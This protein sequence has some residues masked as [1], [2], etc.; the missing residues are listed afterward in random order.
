MQTDLN[1]LFGWSPTGHSPADY[2]L[3]SVH[4]MIRHGDRYPL[5]SIPKTKRPSIDC[6][7]SASR[8]PVTV[9][10][11]TISTCRLIQWRVY[12]YSLAQVIQTFELFHIIVTLYCHITTTNYDKKPS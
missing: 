8:Y 6:S 7:L 9:T 2:K 12:V 11:V 4:V 1:I 10:R 5:Y 3:L